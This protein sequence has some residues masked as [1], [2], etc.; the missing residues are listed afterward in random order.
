MKVGDLVLCSIYP[1]K[2][3]GKIINTITLDKINYYEVYFPKT[4][5]VLSIEEKDIQPIIS[6]LDK[7]KKGAFDNTLLFKMRILSE[8]LDSLL[9]QDKLIAANNFKIVPLPHQVLAVNYVFEQFV[10]A[11]DFGEAVKPTLDEEVVVR[12]EAFLVHSVYGSKCKCN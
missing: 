9:Y 1:D 7:I 4:K 6:P 12:V 8:K 2:E 10:A 11:D 3:Q 5:D